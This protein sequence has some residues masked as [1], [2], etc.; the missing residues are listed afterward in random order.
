MHPNKEVSTR[1][2]GRVS[3]SPHYRADD[4]SVAG[5]SGARRH[6]N[7]VPDFEISPRGQ[8]FVNGDR[9]RLRRV[10]GWIRAT[11]RRWVLEQE[12]GEQKSKH[13]ES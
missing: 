11:G 4:Y 8:R 13:A 10:R 12:G 9:A 6:R 1:N 3:S 7:T 5:G 2:L